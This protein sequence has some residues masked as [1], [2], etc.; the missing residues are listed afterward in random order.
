ML[1]NLAVQSVMNDIG[2]LDTCND[3]NYCVG[4]FFGT[5]VGLLVSATMNHF[6]RLHL[7]GN[8]AFRTL[9]G[10]SRWWLG[11]PVSELGTS[12]A[13]L[14]DWSST[15]RRSAD[16]SSTVYGLTVNSNRGPNY[17]RRQRSAY[18]PTCGSFH[19]SS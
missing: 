16:F 18:K 3:I 11:E 15:F 12:S 19:F 6:R 10:I 14:C 8:A 1:F 17:E 2:R 7:S 4:A 13:R 9:F 5:C